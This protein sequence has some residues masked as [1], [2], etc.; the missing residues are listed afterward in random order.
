M[1]DS[2]H[3]QLLRRPAGLS[4]VVYALILALVLVPF[5]NMAA[6]IALDH[7]V[8]DSS[9]LSA[10][11]NAQSQH[12]MAHGVA[13][14]HD[15]V[16]SHHSQGLHQCGSCLASGHCCGVVSALLP[17]AE[18]ARPDLYRSTHFDAFYGVVLAVPTEPP[19]FH[20]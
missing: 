15:H 7:A 4:R 17:D 2:H 1:N 6:A 11:Q 18:R 10:T 8:V 20:S 5:A 13:Q 3:R 16:K 12:G 9:M 19:R 14:Q